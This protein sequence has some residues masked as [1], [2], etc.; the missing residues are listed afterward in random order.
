MAL[1][2]LPTMA[3]HYLMTKSSAS[4]HTANFCRKLS[5]LSFESDAAQIDAVSDV[6]A[7]MSPL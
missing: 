1:M 3:S 6:R 5:N 4:F 7:I 2:P